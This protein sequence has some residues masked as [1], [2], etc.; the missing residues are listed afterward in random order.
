M[1]DDFCSVLLLASHDGTLALL[2]SAG[3]RM[4][5]F[6]SK[7]KFKWRQRQR[8]SVIWRAVWSKKSNTSCVIDSLGDIRCDVTDMSIIR[9]REMFSYGNKVSWTKLFLSNDSLDS[10]IVRAETRNTS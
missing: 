4:L 3:G 7:S 6:L 1:I 2:F 10:W 8:P 5:I 9:P